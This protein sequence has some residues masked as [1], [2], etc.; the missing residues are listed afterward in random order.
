M[1]IN[2]NDVVS[3][4]NLAQY[5]ETQEENYLEAIKYYKMVIVMQCLI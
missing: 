3:I 5:Y 4:F 1:A 2:K